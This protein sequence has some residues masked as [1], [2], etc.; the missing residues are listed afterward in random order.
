LRLACSTERITGQSRLY[1]CPCLEKPKVGG[2]KYKMPRENGN[3]KITSLLETT[4]LD[5][6]NHILSIFLKNKKLP[7]P[8]WCN[9]TD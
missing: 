1:K 4:K 5:R 2:K 8:L 6:E 7:S 9:Y 3:F